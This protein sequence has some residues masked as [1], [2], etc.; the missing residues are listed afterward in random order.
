MLKLRT[1]GEA[2][3][4]K[5]LTSGCF[6]LDLNSLDCRA[7]CNI[8]SLNEMVE[9]ILFSWDVEEGPGI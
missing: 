2:G 8:C 1:L 4:E 5:G 3:R 9:K 7:G 6:K